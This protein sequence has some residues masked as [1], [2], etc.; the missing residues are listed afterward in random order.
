MVS[1]WKMEWLVAG[2][3]IVTVVVAWALVPSQDIH[4]GTIMMSTLVV[5]II[6]V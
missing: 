3:I 1:G 6:I 4:V 5:F 2:K